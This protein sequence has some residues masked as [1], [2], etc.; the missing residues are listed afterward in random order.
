MPGQVF[1]PSVA[2]AAGLQDR[3]GTIF[4]DPSGAGRDGSVVEPRG[5]PGDSRDHQRRLGL[6]QTRRE[7]LK[8]AAQG[9]SRD[10]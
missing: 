6:A 5:L 7:A 1:A 8:Q 10:V 2:P 4:V 3:A 9:Q